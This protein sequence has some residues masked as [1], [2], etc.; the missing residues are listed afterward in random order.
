MTDTSP[1]SG[2]SRRR[3][4]V[5]DGGAISNEERVVDQLVWTREGALSGAHRPPRAWASA[6]PQIAP[7]YVYTPSADCRPT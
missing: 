1:H 7:P 2:G 6:P 5:G 3:G 4:W